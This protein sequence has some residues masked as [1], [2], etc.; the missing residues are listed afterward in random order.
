MLFLRGSKRVYK[1]VFQSTRLLT[2]DLLLPCLFL[3]ATRPLVHL[4]HSSTHLCF[5]VTLS[6]IRSNSSTRQPVYLFTCPLTC[7]LLLPCLLLEVTRP[8]VNLFTCPLTCVL[9]LPCLLLQATRPLVHLV[10]S[11]THLC[12]SVTLS[13]IRSNS[14]TRQPV[15]LFTCPLTCVLLLPC[16][17][18]EVTRPLVNLFTCPLT[19]VLLLPCLLLQATRSLVHLFTCLLI[20]LPISS[21][22]SVFLCCTFASSS[23]M[24]G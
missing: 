17:L 18:L 9:L 4:V 5:S 19:C 2:C 8:L 13:F 10:H 12:F 15:Y 11:S 20:L 21:L 14:S 22:Q 1:S 24:K 6:F 3:Q 7:V 16:L 23:G